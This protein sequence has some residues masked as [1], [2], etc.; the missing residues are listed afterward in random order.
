MIITRTTC[1]GVIGQDCLDFY[2][3]KRSII[4]CLVPLEIIR[5]GFFIIERQFSNDKYEMGCSIEIGDQM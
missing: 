4:V 1:I 5:L 3:I 2:V